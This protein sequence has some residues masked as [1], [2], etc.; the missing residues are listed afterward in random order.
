MA[1]H[2]SR[3]SKAGELLPKPLIELHGHPFFWWAVESVRRVQSLASL[4]FVVQRAHIAQ[5]GLD[6]A[7][8][9]CYPD[10]R[11]VVL[12]QVT[13]GAAETALLGAEALTEEGALGVLDCDLAFDLGT[14]EPTLEQLAQGS[15]GALCVFN[16]SSP[17]YSYVRLNQECQVIGTVEKVVASEHAIAGFYLFR[18]A[19]VFRHYY[20]QYQTN[21]PY[22][23][24]FV[25]GIYDLMLQQGCRIDLV[26]LSRQVSF[27]TPQ[28]LARVRQEQFLPE[29]ASHAGSL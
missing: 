19:E 25:S 3:F 7:V 21:C 2:A 27:G 23:E 17:A 9:S 20:R 8:L 11:F 5:F 13:S 18:S 16:S 10:A 4:T 26:H 6:Q 22:A 12:D 15:D 14:L 29:W 24:L 1:G 28:E